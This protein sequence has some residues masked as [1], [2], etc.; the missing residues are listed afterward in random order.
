MVGERYDGRGYEWSAS[1]GYRREPHIILEMQ[2]ERTSITRES[3]SFAANAAS[4]RA[5][6]AFSPRL[7]TTAFV[8]YDNESER[9]SVN[10][11]LRFTRSPG[12]DFYLVWNSGWPT[13]LDRGIPWSRPVRGALVVKYVQY[14]RG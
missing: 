6:Y 7:S 4:L 5:D 8:Q 14:W 1:L 13:G 11:R 9:A 2:F 12:S 3:A 10:A